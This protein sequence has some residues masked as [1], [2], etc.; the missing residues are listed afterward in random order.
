MPT[1]IS[2]TETAIHAV[3]NEESTPLTQAILLHSDEKSEGVNTISLLLEYGAD[4]DL[5][6]G[7]GDTPLLSAV[8]VG[9]HT[10]DEIE[11]LLEG[12]ADPC[13]ADRNGKLPV[14]IASTGSIQGMLIEAG[15]ARD[16]DTGVCVRS[17][18]AAAE[19]EKA[20]NIDRGRI[21][22]CLKTE[23]FDP[24]PADGVFGPRTRQ[25][26]QGWQAARGYPRDESIGYLTSDQANTLLDLCRIVLEP[27]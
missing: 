5:R 6:D 3:D 24:G 17:A 15:G 7:E 11:V 1:R 13:L 9:S 10:S 26:L 16:P 4:P 22:S 20:L 2:E 8:K 18:H 23:G 27:K 12:G 21:Q 19:Q 14:E 25:A